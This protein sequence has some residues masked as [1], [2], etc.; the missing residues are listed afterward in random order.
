MAK[1]VKRT[2]TVYEDENT[3]KFSSGPGD[4]G[5]IVHLNDDGKFHPSL[6]PTQGNSIVLGV[7]EAVTAGDFVNFIGGANGDTVIRRARAIPD[8]EACGYV[9]E[10]A[11]VGAAV[12]VY[13]SGVNDKLSGLTNGAPIFLAT[14]PGKV[15][16]EGNEP[17][18]NGEILQNVGNAIS[19]TGAIITIGRLHIMRA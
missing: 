9:L 6:L 10:D 4:A 18:G 3:L 17:G 19:P 16:S 15:V 12:K 14:Q 7:A 5:R 2:G 13:F 11:A 8:Y 1:L